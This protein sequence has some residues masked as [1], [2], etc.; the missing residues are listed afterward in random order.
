MEKDKIKTLR[1]TNHKI[2][3]AFIRTI[4]AIVVLAIQ[5]TMYVILYFGINVLRGPHPIVFRILYEIIRWIGII[6]VFLNYKKPINSGYKLSWTIFILLCPILGTVSYLLFGNGRVLSKKKRLKLNNYLNSYEIKTKEIQNLEIEKPNFSLI[7]KALRKDSGF[8]LY[9]NTKLEFFNDAYLK[10]TDMLEKLRGA[11]KFIFME[12]F[13]FGKGKIM[14]DIIPILE[15]KGK[16]GVEIK[17][18][19]DDIGSIFNRDK[20]I[21]AR[22][23]AI[24]T[25]SFKAWEPLG[26]NIN[27]KINYRDH[28]KIVIIDGQYAYTG[29]DNIADEYVHYIDRFGYWRDTAIRVEGEAVLS[30]IAMFI[31]MWYMCTNQKLEFEKYSKCISR[32]TYSN[33]YVI[34]FGDGPMNKND[35]LYHLF[36]NMINSATK[37]ILISTPYFIIDNTITNAICEKAKQGVEVK[38]LIPGNYDKYIAYTLTKTHV[39]YL[40]PH[41]VK[42]FYFK[43]FN[44]A[45]EI[46]IDNKYSFIGTANMDYRSLILH[47]ED[48]VFFSDTYAVN[49]MYV[50]FENVCSKSTPM[51]YEKFR[52]RNIFVRL[53]E[54]MIQVISPLF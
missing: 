49:Q 38:I 30:F 16:E 41:G 47:F 32:N 27:P 48:G 51:D 6:C 40:I 13:I 39:G 37:S 21:F 53:F 31:S 3:R 44:H 18:I 15:E 5:L 24:K 42:V 50:D 23:Q 45:K 35:P 8:P 46:I 28:R 54:F 2:L 10:H 43:G 7:V 4:F 33:S 20:T 52:K 12:F 22:L 34:P 25:L 14:E 11:K 36:L 26:L 29:G 1:R 17:I 9:K 19:A